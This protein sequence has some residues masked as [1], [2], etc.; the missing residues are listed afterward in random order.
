VGV[1]KHIRRGEI[2]FPSLLDLKGGGGGGDVSK[3]SFWHNVWCRDS[4]L[5]MAY[6]DL[7]S[8]A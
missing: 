6:P 1:W 4:L 3:V 7:F 8:I 5:K 2:S